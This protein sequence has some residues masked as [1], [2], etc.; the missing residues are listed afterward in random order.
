MNLF[1]WTTLFILLINIF[2]SSAQYLSSDKLSG[3]G[4]PF[5]QADIFRTFTDDDGNRIARIYFQILNDD[6]TF[7]KQNSEYVADIQIDIYVNN[8]E[9]EYLVING[10]NHIGYIDYFYARFAEW[11]GLDENHGIE[12]SEQ[13]RISSKYFTSWFY[14]FLKD[15][16]EYY[17]YIFGIEAINDYNSGILSEFKFHIP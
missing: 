14:Y 7:I 13:H 15:Q 2:N 9:K 11:L 8:K 17:P 3:V 6:L 16:E 1:R 4:L 12:F 5:F 10:G